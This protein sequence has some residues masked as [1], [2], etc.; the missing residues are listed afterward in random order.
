MAER[1]NSATRILR[2][3]SAIPPIHANKAAVSVWATVFQVD[4]KGSHKE[5]REVSARLVLLCDETD[6]IRTALTEMKLG[7]D[8]FVPALD[9]LE[10]AFSSLNLPHPWPNVQQYLRPEVLTTLKFA[11]DLMP[12][13]ESPLSAPDVEEVSKM[14]AELI[15]SLPRSTLPPDVRDFVERNARLIHE[16]LSKYPI[17]GL[18]AL[19]EASNQGAIQLIEMKDAL[20]ECAA[21][22]EIGL[23]GRLWCKF[24]GLIEQGTKIEKA[25]QL[26]RKAWKALEWINDKVM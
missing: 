25:Y 14:V 5:A 15:D 1:I 12:D 10:G 3:L 13:E 2:V 18:A 23:L 22:Q 17:T 26:G 21:A 8:V 7:D 20:V 9:S 24:N 19:R 6:K 4:S 16:A 11:R